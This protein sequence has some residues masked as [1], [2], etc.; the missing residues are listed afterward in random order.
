M[1]TIIQKSILAACLIAFPSTLPADNIIIADDFNGINGAALAGRA[2]D[3]VNLP[4]TSYSVNGTT[5][6]LDT[7]GIGNIP[8]GIGLQSVASTSYNSAS[9]LSI[10]SNGGYI[11]PSILTLSATIDTH[12]I[13][14]FTLPD[15]FHVTRGIGLGFFNSA[16]QNGDADASIRFTG[17]AVN[18]G[19]NSYLTLFANGVPQSAKVIVPSGTM[20]RLTYSIDTTTGAITSVFFDSTDLAS[21]FSG[22]SSA[23]I[24]T[25]T[26]TNLMGFYGSSASLGTTGYVGSFVLTSTSTVPEP[27]ST[28][29][30]ICG[31]SLIGLRR[32]RSR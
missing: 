4:G 28:V 20:H 9:W 14:G 17:L 12:S 23:S 27:A 2:P 31:A 30:L 24:F 18:V 29:L 15:A 3:L 13:D 10:G 11:K 22:S 7:S 8:L 16:P 1:K 5:P 25:D 21:T 19:S 26:A 32:R 6:T